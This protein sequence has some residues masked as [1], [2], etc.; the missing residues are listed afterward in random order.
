[1]SGLRTETAWLDSLEMPPEG[2]TI[3][4]HLDNVMTS[5]DD[6]TFGEDAEPLTD[7]YEVFSETLSK[8]NGLYKLQICLKTRDDIPGRT[9]YDAKSTGGMTSLI[10][11]MMFH[12]SRAG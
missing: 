1:M 3:Q 7:R 2:N 8:F 5:H 12:A 10:T 6:E 11:H 4:H 9:N